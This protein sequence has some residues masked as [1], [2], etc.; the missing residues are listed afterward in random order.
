MTHA[1]SGK[2]GY[3]L[4]NLYSEYTFEEEKLKE[5]LK[6]EDT[7][8]YSEQVQ[9]LYSQPLEG[10]TYLEHIK[11]VTENLQL[12]ALTDCGI[13]MNDLQNALIALRSHRWNYRDRNDILSLS[14]YGRY[15]KCWEGNFRIN[16]PI[17]DCRLYELDG[18]EVMLSHFCNDKPTLVMASSLS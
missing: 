4:Y 13:H 18:N 2:R 6:R 11:N 16:D 12:Q 17:S 5:V 14:V 8:R 10:N 15:D 1:S 7:L 9:A 3:R